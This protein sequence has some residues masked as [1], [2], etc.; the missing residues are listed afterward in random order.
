[1]ASSCSPEHSQPCEPTASAGKAAHCVCLRK[2]S[3]PCTHAAVR[4][5]QSSIQTRAIRTNLPAKPSITTALV[6]NQDNDHNHSNTCQPAGHV[7][8]V[9]RIS[10][11]IPR[12]V[13]RK[14]GFAI[15]QKRACDVQLMVAPPASPHQKLR[16]ASGRLP[17]AMHGIKRILYK[18]PNIAILRRICAT[19]GPFVELRTANNEQYGSPTL[20][21]NSGKSTAYLKSRQQRSHSSASTKTSIGPILT[22]APAHV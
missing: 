6:T 14:P 7:P 19:K 21:A 5:N 16:L 17:A 11:T 2:A 10:T 3:R 4:T 13:E 18:P 12:P 9:I 20:L 22:S 1:M 15:A 8:F